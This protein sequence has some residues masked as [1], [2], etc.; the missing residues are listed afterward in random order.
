MCVHVLTC[1]GALQLNNEPLSFVSF[2]IERVEHRGLLAWIVKYADFSWLSHE[3]EK[4][5]ALATFFETGTSMCEA[6]LVKSES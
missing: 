5:P 4:E 3:W 1:L 2:S 6:V